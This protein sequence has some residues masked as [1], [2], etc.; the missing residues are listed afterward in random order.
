MDVP[1]E[2]EGGVGA[3]SCGADKGGPGRIAE[4]ADEGDDLEEEGEGEC[5]GGRDGG[6]DGKGC[7][8][9]KAAGYAL[10]GGIVN[11]KADAWS[12]FGGLVGNKNKGGA[13]EKYRRSR[14]GL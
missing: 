10:E 8:A 5:G 13:R 1:A 2:E 12:N 11:G 6:E 14:R 3:E 9:Y 7:V 4:E